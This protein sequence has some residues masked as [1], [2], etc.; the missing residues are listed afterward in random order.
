[1]RRA[2]ILAQVALVLLVAPLLPVPGTAQT[3]SVWAAWWDEG[4]HMRI[5]VT[6]RPET[7][8]AFDAAGRVPFDT[9][10]QRARN[11]P[12]HVEVDFSET[13][14]RAG[15][16]NDSGE[17]TAFTF[18][19]D[20]VRVVEYTGLGPDDRPRRVDA[21]TPSL[22]VAVRLT[23]EA[24]ERFD[25][26][27]NAVGTVVFLARGDT[28]T[29][30]YYFIYFDI[31]E[32]GDKPPATIPNEDRA[33]LEGL[34]G[35]ARGNVFYGR[36]LSGAGGGGNTITVVGLYRDTKVE[37]RAMRGPGL[38]DPPE[39]GCDTTPMPGPFPGAPPI[40]GLLQRHQVLQ[41]TAIGYETAF[42]VVADKPV[43]ATIGGS[44]P[45]TSHAALVY[46]SADGSL[47]GRHFV[48]WSQS[49]ETTANEPREFVWVV[50]AARTCGRPT[51]WDLLSTG[52]RRLDESPSDTL[53]Y[54][55]LWRPG[56]V[57]GA[58]ELEGAIGNVVVIGT[59]TGLVAGVSP[60]G[61]RGAGSQ[62]L[63]FVRHELHVTSPRPTRVTVKDLATFRNIETDRALPSTANSF[64]LSLAD[65]KIRTLL[66]EGAANDSLSGLVGDPS[67]RYVTPILGPLGRT[68][69]V[70]VPAPG[71]LLLFGLYN[72]TS[73]RVDRIQTDGRVVEGPLDT[74]NRDQFLLRTEPGGYR[75]RAEKPIAAYALNPNGN[76][77]YAYY[78]SGRLLPLRAAAGAADFWGFAGAL[79]I[80]G[81]APVTNVKPGDAVRVELA[82]TNLARDPDGR[83]VSDSFSLDVRLEPDELRT[84]WTGELST[85][86]L[87]DV[88]S[89]AA[90]P[91]LLQ[92]SSPR[93]APTGTLASVR[94][95]ATSAG[96]PAI[97]SSLLLRVSV[98]VRFD[99]SLRFAGGEAVLEQAV[100]PGNTTR[101][102][103]V[104]RNTGSGEDTVRLEIVRPPGLGEGFAFRLADART[105]ANV[106]SVTL[107]PGRAID[108]ELAVTVPR[109]VT[110]PVFSVSVLGTSANQV[111]LK[112]EARADLVLSAN[113]QIRLSASDPAREAL[114]GET[115]RFPLRLENLGEA[116]T[117]RVSLPGRPVPEFSPLLVSAAR[118][119]S[120]P[121]L[122][123]DL[124]ANGTGNDGRDLYLDVAVAPDTAAATRG[125]LVVVAETVRSGDRTPVRETVFLQLAVRRDHRIGFDRD[126]LDVVPG[127]EVEVP[128]TLTNRANADEVVRIL[129]QNLPAG[130][131]ASF[132]PANL[133]LPRNSSGTVRLTLATPLTTPPGALRPTFRLLFEDGES[134]D[135][136]FNATVPRVVDTRVTLPERSLVVPPGAPRDVA[137]T[138]ANRGNV[139]QTVRLSVEAPAGLDVR[140]SRD[141]VRLS[142]G[143]EVGLVATF[144]P[145]RA[146]LLGNAT[147]RF[148]GS[149]EEGRTLL[150]AR[151]VVVAELDLVLSGTSVEDATVGGVLLATA[152]VANVGGADLAGVVATLFVDGVAVDNRTIEILPATETRVV[153]LRWTREP[154][155]HGVAVLVDPRDEFAELDEENNAHESR[156]GRTLPGP[157][158][159]LS[160]LAIAFAF[161]LASAFAL[162]RRPLR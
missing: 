76:G 140:L 70:Y 60:E 1:M 101:F 135:V 41:C 154:G 86:A 64:A 5:P 112:R 104:L 71:Q 25:P 6:V 17:L 57:G 28:T 9:V 13:L 102:P 56:V 63:A 37:I 138:V 52:A 75:I 65:P 73:L 91:F 83:S 90:A 10:D 81:G 127:A 99:F 51:M 69:E 146:V 139:P 105:G 120:G 16:S 20:S 131:V 161:A 14:R 66:V 159:L 92:V 150:G 109:T 67:A 2:A 147:V 88:A 160:A 108:L 94:L 62:I 35:P 117:V 19:P 149:T 157:S 21:L 47:S 153:V 23:S 38:F 82:V 137:A 122:V 26:T 96:N 22:F 32:N 144:S 89:G 36:T 80:V 143:E 54:G 121:F 148:F 72:S 98:T 3:G 53:E 119:E 31:L 59:G 77:P 29:P 142:P 50:C 45:T 107:D 68:Y 61:G 126:S 84:N 141:E 133:T 87:S 134:R 58:W 158:L 85:R 123:F 156:V 113:I 74:L 152:E 100:P 39:P 11:H 114:P 30:R 145:G 40:G 110:V 46:P 7:D 125:N 106:S 8:H 95:T 155:A 118:N 162:V 18:D 12:V 128:L 124:S 103:L 48:F 115:V 42:Q 111:N 27:R 4:W 24:P 15:W 79:S 132:A 34:F 151:E 44:A 78:L 116:V 130:W 129:P 93:D 97:V 49:D 33:L 43:L 136:A 55:E